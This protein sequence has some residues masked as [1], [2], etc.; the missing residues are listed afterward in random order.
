MNPNI[1][2]T[3]VTLM[4]AASAGVALLSQPALADVYKWTD[5][6]GH[7]HFSDSLPQ[8]PSAAQVKVQTVAMPSQVSS[9]PR[10][11]SSAETPSAIESRQAKFTE[12]L[13]KERLAREAI[14]ADQ[15]HRKEDLQR[16]CERARNRLDHMDRIN[17][18]YHENDDGTIRYLSDKEGDQL[19]QAAKASYKESCS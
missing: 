12:Q 11:S 19:R 8:G 16:A 10:N 5:A 3:L 15:Q 6:S 14:Q 17:V 7:A 2:R 1:A 13:H 18:F 4:L 9:A